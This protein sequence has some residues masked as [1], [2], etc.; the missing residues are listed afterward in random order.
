MQTF[1][2]IFTEQSTTP[3]FGLITIDQQKEVKM[4]NRFEIFNNLQRAMQPLAHWYD[5]IDTHVMLEIQSEV[6]YEVLHN[7]SCNTKWAPIHEQV[8]M[9]RKL[10]CHIFENY[11]EIQDDRYISDEDT[12]K[13]P[14][15][16][17]SSPYILLTKLQEPALQ[18]QLAIPYKAPH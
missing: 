5:I 12:D 11:A 3:Q 16:F 8:T 1:A 15:T 9:L 6:V 13:Y 4:A 10:L 17:M 14:E 18:Q 7:R 2:H